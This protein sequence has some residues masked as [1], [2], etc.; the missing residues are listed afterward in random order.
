MKGVEEEID[1]LHK[2][3]MK[4][5]KI[6]EEILIT[7]NNKNGKEDELSKVNVD[8]EI[9]KDKISSLK[10]QIEELQKQSREKIEI[11]RKMNLYGLYRDCLK[12]I[13]LKLI[14][15]I[16]PLLE[17]KINDLLTVVTDFTLQFEITDSKIEIYLN[18][19]SYKG[20]MIMIRNSSGFERFI[21]SLAIRIALMEISQ[22]SSPNMM[23]IDEGWSC[24]DNENI[25]N[26]G[27]I[28]DHLKMKF[29][30]ILT[31]SHMQLIRQNCDTQ[32]SLEKDEKGFS[33]VKFGS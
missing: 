13:P 20:R 3:G 24:F 10:G 21:S 5:K 16:K 17:R 31:I 14:A 26:I 22:L 11:E 4:N 8:I 30:F 19:P 7:M 2:E 12:V 9:V 18:R 6:H 32:I 23:A 29:D 27:V 15:Q 33:S 1:K 28:L 25:G